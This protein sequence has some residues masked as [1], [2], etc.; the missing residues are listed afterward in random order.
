LYGMI[1]Y[2]MIMHAQE[3]AR[4][5]DQAQTSRHKKLP[6]PIG[7]PPAK[8]GKCIHRQTPRR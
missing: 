4:L 6:S 7:S 5:A 8:T 3:K 2:L 1:E